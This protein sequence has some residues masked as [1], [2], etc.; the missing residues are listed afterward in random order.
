MGGGSSAVVEAACLESRRSRVRTPL[1][2]KKK[3]FTRSLVKIQYCE[4]LFIQEVAC[5]AS[6]RQGLNFEFYV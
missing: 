6:D 3:F 2:L 4:N 5:S 1:K